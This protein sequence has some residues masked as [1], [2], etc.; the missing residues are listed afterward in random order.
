MRL[1]ATAAATPLIGPDGTVYPNHHL[2]TRVQREKRIE[3]TLLRGEN[4]P[5][6]AEALIT[7]EDLGTATRVKMA[8]VLASAEEYE[9]V[10]SFGAVELGLQTLGKL[11]RYVGAA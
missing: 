10:R 11:A 9:K 6:H 7:F 1:A 8:M 5:R 4:G 3:Y 2:Y